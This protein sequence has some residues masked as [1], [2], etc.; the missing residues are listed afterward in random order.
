[1]KVA[2]DSIVEL[3]S[4]EPLDVGFD[5]RSVSAVKHDG[6]T[7]EMTFSGN[8][9]YFNEAVLPPAAISVIALGDSGETSS[10]SIEFVS[11]Y[12]F[13]IEELRASHDDSDDFTDE[14]KYPDERIAEMRRAAVEVFEKNAN[15]C[16]IE[17]IGATFSYKLDS[18]VSLDHYDVTELIFSPDGYSLVSFCQ[19]A[20]CARKGSGL[21]VYRYGAG[22]LPLKVKEAVINLTKYYLRS[23]AWSERAQSIEDNGT[24][25]RMSIAG[26]DGAT[27]LPEIDAVITQFGNEVLPVW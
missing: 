14:S 9:V 2:A 18:V 4:P 13:T 10:F 15:K 19:A 1:M 24:F 22:V 27:G 8:E 5:V 23:T 16:F 17:R 7:V 12:Y 11:R 20:G 6:S 25:I 3:V 21:F 26:R